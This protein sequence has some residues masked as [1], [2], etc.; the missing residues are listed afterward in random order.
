MKQLSIVKTLARNPSTNLFEEVTWG[1]I[2]VI[3]N[4]GID[5]SDATAV[6]S[7]LLSGKTAYV[8]GIKVTGNIPL[9][10]AQT[11]IPSTID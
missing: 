4:Q 3:N 7:D 1:G 11:Y 9:K 2:R 8:D 6:P 5:T 10:A